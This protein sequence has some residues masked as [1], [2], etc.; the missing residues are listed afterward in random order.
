MKMADHSSGSE[1]TISQR[2]RAAF[3][4]YLQENPSNH[5]ISQAERANLIDWLTNP[6]RRPSSQPEFSRRNYARKTFLYDEENDNLFAVAKKDEEKNR[7]VVTEDVIVDVVETVHQDNGHAGW[8]ATWKDVNKSYHG[9]LRSDVIF[10]LKQCGICAANPRKRPKGTLAFVPDPLWI[11]DVGHDCSH[12]DDVSCEN[13]FTYDPD[14][15]GPPG[16]QRRS[17]GKA[18]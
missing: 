15:E 8:D 13:F 11:A 5:R 9:I 16:K 10:L 17:S 18:S 2:A 1:N 14:D 4:R 6:H 12:V 3:P 7:R